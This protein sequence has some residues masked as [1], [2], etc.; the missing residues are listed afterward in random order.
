MDFQQIR[1]QK[2]YEK[3]AEQIKDMIEKGDLRPGD[4]LLSVRELA[5]KF[6]VGRSA[7][8]EALSALQ[9]MGLIELKQGE[10]TFVRQLSTSDLLGANYSSMLLE[11][12]QVESLLE[13]RKL[14][15][16]SYVELAAE[17]RDYEDLKKMEDA[18]KIMKEDLYSDTHG[19]EA[20]WLFHY[21]I[22]K[23]TKNEM[24]VY[25]I[26]TISDSMKRNLRTNRIIL[27][28]KPGVP[29]KLL[30]EHTEIY[31]AIEEKD[32]KKAKKLLY[33]HLQ[34]V[35]ELIKEIIAE[36]EKMED[37]VNPVS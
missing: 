21:A 24:L 27:Y 29:E 1:P 13:V 30:E 18:L 9:A 17:R 15:E 19:E 5:E 36:N 33:Q 2:I 12:E 23:A 26:E 28:K 10:G 34:Q 31:R 22:A 14:I 20:D 16:T 7:V 6:N 4:K 37:G 11:F 35:E 25:I 32:G 3:V 8:R